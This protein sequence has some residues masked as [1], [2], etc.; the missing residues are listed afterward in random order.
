[1]EKIELLTVI[2]L[3]GLLFS[4]IYFLNLIT[5]ETVIQIGSTLWFQLISIFGITAIVIYSGEV[6]KW[7]D[8]KLA[9][10]LT[11][12]FDQWFE[13]KLRARHTLINS[14]WI[15]PDASIKIDR[16]KIGHITRVTALEVWMTHYPIDY[17]F[18]FDY[19]IDYKES[20]AA[21]SRVLSKLPIIGGVWRKIDDEK[22]GIDHSNP[23]IEYYVCSTDLIPSTQDKDFGNEN[24][25]GKFMKG[26]NHKFPYPEGSHVFRVTHIYYKNEEENKDCTLLCI[27]C[28]HALTDGEG[29][30]MLM[31]GWANEMNNKEWI[32]PSFD[33]SL[34][35][36]KD[37]ELK[38]FKLDK[39]LN[40]KHFDYTVRPTP[41][42]I[43]AMWPSRRWVPKTWIFTKQ[44]IAALK[45]KALNGTH[46]EQLKSM[47]VCMCVW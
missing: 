32:I 39:V 41:W 11:G 7:I 37:S 8:I 10:V 30:F 45:Q 25:Y 5:I 4:P 20:Q 28:A 44:D 46:G 43:T 18:F 2:L 15:K 16:D 26:Y 38:K 42:M 21:L 47:Y 29:F 6:F 40:G 13:R 33:R 23:C 17:T 24:W 1:M 22:L 12:I 31:R 36:I 27:G 35:I 14:T 9:Y 19:H 34:S 3:L